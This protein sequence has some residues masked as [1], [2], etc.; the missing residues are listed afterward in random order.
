M[1]RIAV[2]SVGRSDR[3]IYLPILDA[4]QRHRG[5]E[6]LIVSG[7][8]EPSDKRSKIS[9]LGG[10]GHLVAC[11]VPMPVSR[12]TGLGVAQSMAKGVAGFGKALDR[13]KPDWILVL[14]DRF[15]MLAAAVA[16]APLKIPVAHLHGGESSQGALDENF[17]HAIT[18]LSHVHFVSASAHAARVHQLGEEKWRIVVCGAPALEYARRQSRAVP[19]PVLARRLGIT[20]KPAP[21]L[22]TYHPETLAST[23]V[24]NDFSEVLAALE[25]VTRQIVFTAPNADEG[26]SV[27]RKMTQK[28]VAQRPNAVF[29]ESLDGCYYRMLA[30]ASVMVG[31]SSSGIIESGSFGLPVVD[32]GRRQWGRIRGANVI[33]SAAKREEIGRALR[34]A[35][36]PGFATRAASARNPY[37]PHGAAP[38]KLVLQNLARLRGRK[39]LLQKNFHD[40]RNS[41]QQ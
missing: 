14:G 4:L 10:F 12:D 7:G 38:S 3:S 33:H 8:A 40:I 16:A 37:E 30:S 25:R 22:V 20:L 28:F 18:K 24:K 15:E 29:V 23:S 26:S 32:I 11:R 17:R 39:D 9:G 19:A 6:P 35:L 1:M 36:S 5:F 34:R 2:I 31:N 21:I 41:W 27:I 13:L